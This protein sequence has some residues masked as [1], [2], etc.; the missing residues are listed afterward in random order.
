MPRLTV[1]NLVDR[2]ARRFDKPFAYRDDSVG[3]RHL[4]LTPDQDSK[5]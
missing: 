4:G 2:A 3:Y 5:F 1:V